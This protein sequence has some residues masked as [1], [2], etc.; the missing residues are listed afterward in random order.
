MQDRPELTFPEDV[1]ALVRSS[2]CSAGAILEYG[3]GGSTILAAEIPNLTCFSVE[4]DKQWAI[5][6]QT[7]VDTNVEAHGVVI[8]YSNVGETREWGWPKQIRKTMLPKYARYPR[9][10]WSREDFVHPDIVL[11]DGRFRVGCFLACITRIDRPT[12]ILFDVGRLVLAIA[13]SSP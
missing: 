10:V 8:H 5:G 12:K 13:P 6:V 7:W 1:A 4:S 9:S 3:S 11:I 2:Y